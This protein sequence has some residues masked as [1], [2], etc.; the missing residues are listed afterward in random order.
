MLAPADSARRAADVVRVASAMS[1]DTAAEFRGLPFAVHD[2]HRFVLP[3]GTDGVVA[4][5]VRHLNEEAN[6]REEHI[7]LILERDST[8]A[9]GG[10]PAYV[11]AYVERTSGREDDIESWEVLAGVLLGPRRTPA[12]IVSRDDGDGGSY[13]LL[14]RT[15]PGKWQVA[16]NS[17]YTGC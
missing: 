3:D 6:P 15:G 17:A 16:W 9:I 2:A 4:E 10:P 13:T 11:P 8:P 5:L 12:M 14:T 7:L 1:D